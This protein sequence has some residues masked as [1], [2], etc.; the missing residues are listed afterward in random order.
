MFMAIS[1]EVRCLPSVDHTGQ[2]LIRL[3]IKIHIQ[4]IIFIFLRTSFEKK[5][6]MINFLSFDF[7]TGKKIYCLIAR[8][9]QLIFIL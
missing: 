3:H 9:I 7:Y 5:N 4:Y 2:V 8:K 1:C 6:L